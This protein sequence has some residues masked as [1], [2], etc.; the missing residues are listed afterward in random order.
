MMTDDPQVGRLERALQDRADRDAGLRCDR[1]LAFSLLLFCGRGLLNSPH[2]VL[3]VREMA[4]NN[5]LE[6][7]ESDVLEDKFP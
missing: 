6:I 1:A 3:Y 7:R 5:L 4:R 2:N